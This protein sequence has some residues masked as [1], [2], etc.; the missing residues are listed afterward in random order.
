[1]T[2]TLV[3]SG[4]QPF[5]DTAMVTA[6][7]DTILGN[8]TTA[9][10]LRTSSGSGSTFQAAFRG[11]N[12][13]PGMPV[14]ISFVEETGGITTVRPSDVRADGSLSRSVSAAFASCN[15]LIAAVNGDDTVQ[16]QTSGLLTLTT[17]QWDAV[18][19][20]SGGL[21]RGFPYYVS[22][23]PDASLVLTEPSGPGQWVTA[24]GAAINAT[25]MLI[26]PGVPDQNLRDAIVFGSWEGSPLLLGSVVRVTAN[27][28]VGNANNSSSTNAQAIGVV[29]A[30]DVNDNPI[31]QISGAVVLDPL[32]WAAVTTNSAILQAGT[33]YFVAG[34]GDPGKLD[35]TP[36]SNSVQVGVAF[37]GA[38]LIL[39]AP[40]IIVTGT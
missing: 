8:G 35:P 16:V 1:M 20:Q 17:A 26:Q 14:F 5:V 25:T 19:A 28:T 21:D 6:D 40:P 3:R 29:A 27:A 4:G 37:S 15:G 34:V 13:L 9:D 18:T 2:D 22:V 11:S 32:D 38:A 39:C 33:A 24:V 23:L 7:Q 12:P 30:L 31:V 10:P 36:G